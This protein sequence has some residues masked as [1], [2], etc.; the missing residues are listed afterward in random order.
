[1]KNKIALLFLCIATKL[2][3]AQTYSPAYYAFVKKADSLYKAKEYKKAALS[4]SSAFETLG[5][6]GHQVDRY[7]AACAWAMANTPDSAFDCLNRIIKKRL[8]TDYERLTN[9][10]DLTSLHTDKRWQTLLDLIKL[11]NEYKVPE[12][13]FIAGTTEDKDK[14]IIGVEKGAGQDGKNGATIKVI[15]KNIT[16]D[17]F[18]NLMQNFLPDKF[19]N[20]R[21]RMSGY[22]KSKDADWASFWFR[23]DQNG[24]SKSL[25]FDNMIDG[26]EKRPIKGTTDWKK[27]EI[28]L[29]V[30][31]KASNIAF[32]VMLGT[33]GQVW[34]D[35]LKFEIV[36]NSV[37]TT[38]KDS[39]TEPANLN[40][41]E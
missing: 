10:K 1:M 38:G 15:E 35:N 32:G 39:K 20:K 18:G 36:D 30:P 16:R 41:E 25:A 5:W 21:V 37:P 28:V 19:L 11:F 8:F 40:F 3:V 33:N 23:V 27:Y 7:S 34:F 4:Y 14:Y 2:L 6:K 9:E 26:K 24:S 22:M 31:E 12:G 13:W 17:G 29:D